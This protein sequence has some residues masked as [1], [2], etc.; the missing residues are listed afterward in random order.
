M[1]CVKRRNVITFFQL[2]VLLSSQT[3]IHWNFLSSKTG[4]L[5]DDKKK[6]ILYNQISQMSERPHNWMLRM[7]EMSVADPENA[8]RG[9]Q[10]NCGRSAPPSDW[11]HL[12][13]K[14]KA[15]ED[16][17]LKWFIV[18]YYLQ[19]G[20]KNFFKQKRGVQPPSPPQPKSSPDCNP[21]RKN[22]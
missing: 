7:R 21:N 5:S 17:L 16:R 6:N 4:E 19:Y 3:R 9:S 1:R 22:L 20:Y 12:G 13:T 14:V 10:R 11:E 15:L 2:M 8:E 18:W